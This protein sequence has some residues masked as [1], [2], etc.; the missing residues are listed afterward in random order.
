MTPRTAARAAP[1]RAVPR[2]T[3]A[4]QCRARHAP[5]QPATRSWPAPL[6][7]AYPTLSGAAL[8]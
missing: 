2:A 4:A 7:W 1:S 8:V 6:T 3:P 5:P